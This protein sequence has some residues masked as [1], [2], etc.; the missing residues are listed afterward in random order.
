MPEN[1]NRFRARAYSK[2]SM[3]DDGRLHWAPRTSDDTEGLVAPCKLDERVRNQNWFGRVRAMF[4]TLPTV[5]PVQSPR[6]YS[7]E[8]IERLRVLAERFNRLTAEKKALE[9]RLTSVEEEL[10]AASEAYR[11]MA[12]PQAVS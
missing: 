11:Q 3:G 12:R 9:A 10:A 1:R 2:V 8:E 7:A 4:A 6:M 5:R